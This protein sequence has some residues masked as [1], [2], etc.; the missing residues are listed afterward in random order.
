MWFSILHYKAY[1]P[2]ELELINYD[3]RKIPKGLSFKL[4]SYIP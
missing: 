3:F 1:N 4:N 2:L